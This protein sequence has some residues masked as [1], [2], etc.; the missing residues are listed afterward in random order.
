MEPVSDTVVGSLAI[1]HKVV[2]HTGFDLATHDLV[3]EH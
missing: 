3:I 2:L 1:L